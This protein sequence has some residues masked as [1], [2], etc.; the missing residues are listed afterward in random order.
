MFFSRKKV[1]VTTFVLHVFNAHCGG[2]FSIFSPMINP[3]VFAV[4]NATKNNFHAVQ[5]GSLYRSAQPDAKQL[6]NNIKKYGI[7][8]VINLRGEHPHEAWWRQEQKVCA[9]HRVSF[10]NIPMSALTL[11][12]KEN[13]RNLLAIYDKAPCPMLIH[14]QAGADR[15]GEA[16]ALWCLE[17]GKMSK[18]KALEQLTPF[19]NHYTALYPNKRRFITMWAGRSWFERSYKP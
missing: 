19:Y 17:K 10:F 14:C 15:T 11:P 12:S 1:A 13:V 2:L 6:A 4:S 9:D 5:K 3:A 16:A 8:S 18:N 7:K